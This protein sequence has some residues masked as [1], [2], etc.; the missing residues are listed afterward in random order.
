M[1]SNSLF[2][3]TLTSQQW[4]HNNTHTLIHNLHGE[5]FAITTRVAPCADAALVGYTGTD[6][7]PNG[8]RHV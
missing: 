2:T 1:T 4:D 8:Q 7:P 3:L 5:E 6:G